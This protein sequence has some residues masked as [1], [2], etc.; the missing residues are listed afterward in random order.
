MYQRFSRRDPFGREGLHCLGRGPCP[1]KRELPSIDGVI[2]RWWHRWCF[3]G[4]PS[5][6][7][8][9]R[10]PALFLMVHA[11]GRVAPADSVLS[12]EFEDGARA[13]GLAHPAILAQRLSTGLNPS[14]P[15]RSVARVRTLRKCFTLFRT[16]WWLMGESPYVPARE[17]EFL[18]RRFLSCFCRLS[19]NR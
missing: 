13:R 15:V 17:E 10:R 16:R 14:I 1:Q 9:L 18:I 4:I 8:D 5:T 11:C 6:P 19:Q 2:T 3:W 12:S 7:D